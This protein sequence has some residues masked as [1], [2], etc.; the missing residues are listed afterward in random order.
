MKRIVSMLLA[1]TLILALGVVAHADSTTEHTIT[2][3]SPNASGTHSYEV[4][5]VFA[6][7]YEASTGK[8]S[9]I[10]WG[11]GVNGSAL[12]SALQSDVVYGQAFAEC[13][14]AEEVAEVLSGYTSNGED[15][16]AI[17]AIIKA[18][19][20][21]IVAAE[22]P[23]P[24][25]VT[26][27]GY[28][29]VMDVT[30]AEDMGAGDTYSD[31]ILQV[32]GDV[33]ATA[34]DAKAESDK[35]VAEDGSEYGN[36]ADYAI[37]DEVPYLLSF[38]VPA[39]YDKY[40]TY[41]VIFHD[42]MSDG[43]TFNPESVVVKIDG[44]IITAGYTVNENPQ[45]DCTF[46][47]IILNLKGVTGANA[48]A[49]SVVTV[50][51]TAILNENAVIT[52]SGNENT[53]IV[54]FSNDPHNSSSTGT[55]PETEVTVFTYQLIINKVDN[56][57]NP[58]EGAGFTL[59]MQVDAATEGA[60]TAAEWGFGESETDYYLAIGSEITGVTTFEWTGLDS[61]SYVLV[62][63]TTP[64]G[65]NT[66]DP[67]YF[68][69]VPVFDNTADDPV[70]IGL[71]GEVT[72]GNAEFSAEASTA[73]LTANIVNNSGSVLPVTG[74]AGT[75][76][77]VAVGSIAVISALMFIITRKRVFAMN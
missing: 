45:D 46:E 29:F 58:L 19:L 42:A 27:D 47:V 43:L 12:L 52:D 28:Y 54:E 32:C 75:I 56:A 11:S 14:T 69:I 8:L 72:S 30:P 13:T 74:G 59:Y 62:E 1:A 50:E 57:G 77:L 16:A 38:T 24:L 53:L 40:D 5:Q 3:T 17:A 65:Y 64:A 37:G 15:I 39:D 51:Y 7:D 20:S 55:T 25:T 6:G 10:V 2:I 31:Y 60:Q 22:G 33:T 34:K 23:S 36:A 4:Y 76:L 73:M 71:T 61:G 35:Q 49:G 41:T 18:N 26:G 48:S 66:I 70:L 68:T 21:N 67:I 63:T 9:N 44:L